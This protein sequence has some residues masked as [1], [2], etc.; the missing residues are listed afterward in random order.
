MK[1]V[2]LTGATGRIGPYVHEA[3]IEAGYFVRVATP[4]RPK[5]EKNTEW[6]EIDFCIA[7]EIDYQA[8]V[9]DVEVVIHMAAELHDPLRMEAVNVMASRQLAT[10][11]NNAGVSLFIYSSSVGVYGHP[12]VRLI[13]ESTPVLAMDKGDVFLDHKFLYDYCITKLKGEYAIRDVLTV[14]PLIVLRFSNVV[15][16]VQI[17]KLSEWGIARILWRGGRYTHQIYAGDVAAAVLYFLGYC[18]E[19]RVMKEDFP[20]Y[21]LSNDDIVDNTYVNFFRRLAKARGQMRW[22]LY[23]IVFPSWIDRL[24]DRLKYRRWRIGLPSGSVRYSPAKLIKHGFRH[25][26]GIRAVQNAVIAKIIQKERV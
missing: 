17:E 4:D 7:E 23:L 3:L 20:V 13:D 24:K 22:L 2:L 16:E 9:V 10:A 11:A 15:T 19:G 25:K 1:K 8:L 21:I 26:Y 5:F 18:V 6:V 12:C 14:T